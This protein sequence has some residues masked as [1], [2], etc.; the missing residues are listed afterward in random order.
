MVLAL[1]INLDLIA[2]FDKHSRSVCIFNTACQ[3]R[4][5]NVKNNQLEVF[6]SV[7]VRF[8]RENDRR[9]ERGTVKIVGVGS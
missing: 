2:I 4:R 1:M 6:H 5:R 7:R 9:G 3:W 8:S